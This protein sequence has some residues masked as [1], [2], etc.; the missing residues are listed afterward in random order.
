LISN[1]NFEPRSLGASEYVLKLF[2]PT[3]RTAIIVRNRSTGQTVQRIA[4]AETIAESNFQAWLAIQN[5][6]GSDVYIGMNPLR[7]DAHSRTKNDI[8]DIRHVYLD[9][10]RDGDASL[11]AIRMSAEVPAPNFVLDTSPGKHQIV[12]NVS[13]ISQDEAESLLRNLANQF[14]GDMAATD[15]TRVLRLPGFANR[16]LTDEFV[17]QARH[18]SDAVYTRPA[19]TV[20]EGTPESPRRL[21]NDNGRTRAMPNDHKSQSERDWAY[22]K[23]ALARGDD[24]EKVIRTIADYRSEDKAD[25]SYYARRTVTQAQARLALERSEHGSNSGSKAPGLDPDIKVI[26]GCKQ[27]T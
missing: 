2:E 14:G 20:D 13:G 18:E 10:D 27:D 26:N 5:A 9:L 21:S 11:E 19:F 23:R 15:S 1:N 4:T 7:N 8:R 17:V 22:A 3:D 24:P 12:W 25:P 6:R 16:K